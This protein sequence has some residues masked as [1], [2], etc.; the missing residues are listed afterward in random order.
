[1]TIVVQEKWKGKEG[2]K[3][4]AERL[5]TNGKRKEEEIISQRIINTK[6]HS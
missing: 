5:D 6:A 2:G 1:M 3:K 4:R